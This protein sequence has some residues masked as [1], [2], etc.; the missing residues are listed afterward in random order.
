[1]LL[2]ASCGP[3]AGELWAIRRRVIDLLHRELSVRFALKPIR[4]DGA[5]RLAQGSDCRAPEVPGIRRPHALPTALVL[6]IEAALSSPGV[7]AREG[8]T[9]AREDSINGDRADLGWTDD[10]T[11]PDRL[12]FVT[13]RGYPVRH[14]LFYRRVFRPAVRAALLARLRGSSR[15][16]T[17]G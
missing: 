12:I 3:R 6:L 13:A 4:V 5:S 10:P 11:D 2:D 15:S 7:R 8:Y 1:V 9:V 14:N 17:R 16:R